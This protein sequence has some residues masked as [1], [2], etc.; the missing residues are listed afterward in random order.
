VD[1]PDLPHLIGERLRAARTEQ[2]LSVGGLAQAAG[3]GKGSLS[4]IENG[5]R[6]PTLST[7]YGLANALGRPLSWLLAEQVGAQVSSPGIAA[8]LL[9]TSVTGPPGT[10]DDV[11][12][13]VYAIRLEPG[14]TH[15]SQAHGP[16]VV[17]HLLVVRGR[18]AAGRQGA[19]VTLDTGMSTSWVSDGP[20]SY[21][22]LD[23]RPADV[24]LVI[25]WEPDGAGPA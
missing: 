13:E 16:A 8:R 18:V 14:S 17:E 22:A 11:T 7:L 6:N 3:I 15:V 5:T 23:E 25:R 21:R 20:H 4:E 19:E 9:D 1:S 12:V 2:G 10:D 24:V